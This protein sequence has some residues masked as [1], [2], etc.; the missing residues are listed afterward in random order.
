M[1]SINRDLIFGPN[2][3]DIPHMIPHV[4]FP[5]QHSMSNKEI[6]LLILTDIIGSRTQLR[7]HHTISKDVDASAATKPMLNIQKPL[8]KGKGQSI[9]AFYLRHL[10]NIYA[11]PNI[12]IKDADKV[13]ELDSITVNVS[14]SGLTADLHHDVG[15]GCATLVQGKR[16][17]IMYPPTASNLAALWESYGKYTSIPG[18]NISNTFSRLCDGVAFLQTQGQTLL[19]PPLSAHTVFTLHTSILIGREV[20][21]KRSFPQRL[22]NEK[23]Q[24]AW[25]NI[26]RDSTNKAQ[27][28]YNHREV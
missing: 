24:V 11:T 2:S 19:V 28:E 27:K 3:L 15:H 6:S 21:L 17:W 22:R 23:L 5:S 12:M 4:S 9:W 18:S 16:L 10:A 13:I 20:Y 14:P 8:S 25:M 7:M 26:D 1:N